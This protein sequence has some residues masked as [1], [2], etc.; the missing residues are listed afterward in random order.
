M[1]Q[2][3]EHTS[4]GGDYKLP[5]RGCEVMHCHL[6]RRVY[7]GAIHALR[8]NRIW[9]RHIFLSR[10]IC[11]QKTPIWATMKNGNLRAASCCL[12]ACLVQLYGHVRMNKKTQ[13]RAVVS[14]VCR[15]QEPVWYSVLSPK[16]C[17]LNRTCICRTSAQVNKHKIRTE[18]TAWRADKR[19]ALP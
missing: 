5:E 12:P 9:A 14:K 3:R 19:C 7:W 13:T 1:T 18:N 17:S 10:V 16:R 4:N 11:V 8:I 6:L 2:A 15:T